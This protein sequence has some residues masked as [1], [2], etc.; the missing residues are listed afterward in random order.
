MDSQKSILIT[1]FIIIV[2]VNSKNIVHVNA[3]GSPSANPNSLSCMD[4]MMNNMASCISFISKG[5]TDS[6]PDPSC[7]SGLKVVLG[8]NAECLC[9]ALKS[10][11]S[12]GIQID[13]GRAASLPSACNVNA[14]PISKCNGPPSSSSSPP[15]EQQDPNKHNATTP[16]AQPTPPP[17]TPTTAP[18]PSPPI[19]SSKMGPSSS[20][21][22][23]STLG[24]SSP[25]PTTPKMGSPPS[26]P[27]S[28][29]TGPSPSSS[30]LAPSKIP[31]IGSSSPLPQTPIATTMVPL[32]SPASDDT[33][34]TTSP[35][36]SSSSS[37]VSIIIPYVMIFVQYISLLLCIGM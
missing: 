21:S 18:S 32:P 13:F 19:K 26:P 27:A 11:G 28:S 29:T 1:L 25:P 33:S 9:E 17:A 6:K 34:T 10:G 37:S 16:R 30:S 35:P 5:G 20:P 22:A 15:S 24:P 14:P 23:S 2:T 12:L 3:V 4:L 8:T 36:H 31:P 7:C